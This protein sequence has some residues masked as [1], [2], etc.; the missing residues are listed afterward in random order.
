MVRTPL[1]VRN[2][3]YRHSELIRALTPSSALGIALS[4]AAALRS[5]VELDLRKW[6]GLNPTYV[7][8]AAIGPK[9]WLM[10]TGNPC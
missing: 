3:D 1:N 10:D 6:P 9:K 4:E 7:S 5:D 8:A 2:K